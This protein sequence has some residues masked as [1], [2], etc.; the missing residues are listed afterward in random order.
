MSRSRSRLAADWFSNLKANAVTGEVEGASVIKGT[1]L[2]D[3]IS[4]EG[5][6]FYDT[7]ADALYVSKGTSWAMLTNPPPVP[8]GGTVILIPTT[9]SAGTFDYNLGLDFEDADDADTALTYSLVS[10]TMPGGCTLPTEGNTAFTGTA[11]SVATDTI[12]T[13]VIGA[14]DT[15]G[16]I[17]T[18]AYQQQ[19]NTVVPS[20]TGGTITITADGVAGFASTYDSSAQFTYA[21]GASESSYAISAGS[22][23][24]GLALNTS[25]G[26]ISGTNDANASSITYNFTVRATDTDG[27][28][29]DQAYSWE[30]LS[31][32]PP[33]VT[34]GTVTIAPVTETATASYDVDTNFTFAAGHTISAFTVVSGALPSGLSLNATTGVISGTPSSAS[35]YTFTIR[36][37]N[38]TGT[39]AD[40]SYSW[41]IN[42][43]VVG[44]ST[45][46]SPGSYSWVAP[47]N[48]FAVSV[49]A[50]GGGAGGGDASAAT[51]SYFQQLSLVSGGGAWSTAKS[52]PNRPD[53]PGAGGGTFTG[54]GGGHGGNGIG[55]YSGAGGAGGY[56]GAA[57][58]ASRGSADASS[59]GAGGSSAGYGGSSY[60]GDT[61]AGGGGVGLNGQGSTGVSGIR[62][63]GGSGGASGG[64]PSSTRGGDGGQYGGGGGGAPGGWAAGAGGGLGWKNNIP[65][66]PGTSYNVTVG[67]GSNST[68]GG[69]NG[70]D[71]AV[72]IIWGAGRSFPYNAS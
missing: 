60:P 21:T 23:P 31:S 45:Y 11:T 6:L 1:S 40:Q 2:P 54:D 19:V 38:T 20:V 46:T 41:Q 22:L 24:P 42:V 16:G 35:T 61:T 48:V 3:P 63:T 56:T 25:T 26:V 59:G 29:V 18:Q 33:T 44:S 70:G 15:E 49:V 50:V 51:D 28:T 69:G 34:G 64:T 47:A 57:G 13:W 65:V 10:G 72:R 66:T 36:G 62:G 55:Y 5:T 32:I 8:T 68:G 67:S 27:D 12:Y 9:E 37:T 39:S 14:T 53:S 17:S 71:G 43:N 4:D 58:G 52:Y 7:V 30:I